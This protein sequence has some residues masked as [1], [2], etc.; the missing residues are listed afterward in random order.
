MMAESEATWKG[1]TAEEG[2]V[3]GKFMKES[4]ISVGTNRY[5]LSPGQSYVNAEKKAQ[6]PAFWSA[7]K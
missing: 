1:V 4:V 5:R 2:A 6:D 7:N 3:L